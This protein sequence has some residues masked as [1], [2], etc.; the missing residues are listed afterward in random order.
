MVLPGCSGA[1]VRLTAD[2]CRAPVSYSDAVPATDG[3]FYGVA[4]GRLK[5]V[6]SFTVRIHRVSTFF[7]LIPLGRRTCDLSKFLNRQLERHDGDAIVHL[8]VEV[9][10]GGLTGFASIPPL[11]AVLPGHVMC[12]VKGDVA[13]VTD[14]TVMPGQREDRAMAPDPRTQS[15]GHRPQ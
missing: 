14:R 12:V 6:H 8:R 15:V 9:Q 5:V 13:V 2:H 3:K 1:S 11:G 4:N 10:S 7:G